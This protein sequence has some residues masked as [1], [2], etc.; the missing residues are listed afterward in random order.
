MEEAAAGRFTQHGEPGK[1]IASFKA[2][3]ESTCFYYARFTRDFAAPGAGHS[4]LL[5]LPSGSR[6]NSSQGDDIL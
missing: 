1:P 5:F 6:G 2:Y 4:S 3:T